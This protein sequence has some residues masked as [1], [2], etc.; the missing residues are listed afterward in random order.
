MDGGRLTGWFGGL[1]GGWFG[2]LLRDASAP[3]P[4]N[5]AALEAAAVAFASRCNKLD[6]RARSIRPDPAAEDPAAEDPAA[7]DPAAEDPAAEDPTAKPL[8]RSD[9][10]AEPLAALN[11]AALTGAASGEGMGEVQLGQLMSYTRLKPG[12][13]MGTFLLLAAYLPFGCV[14]ALF[15]VLVTVIAG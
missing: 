4:A 8:A 13:G 3:L 5:S 15:R 9:G 10:A 7:K 11:G 14:L 12:T 6:H 2:G 1:S